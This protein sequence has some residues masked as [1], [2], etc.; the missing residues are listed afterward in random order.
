M[1]SQR[2]RYAPAFQLADSNDHKLNVITSYDSSKQHANSFTN[3]HAQHSKHQTSAIDQPLNKYKQ[4]YSLTE[5]HLLLHQHSSEYNHE[6]IQLLNDR[7]IK[8]PSTNN[9]MQIDQTNNQSIKPSVSTVFKFALLA[10]LVIRNSASTLII[11]YSQGVLHEKYSVMSTVLCAEFLKMFVCTI[12][13]MVGAS[14]SPSRF[15]SLIRSSLPMALPAVLYL[16]QNKLNYIALRSLPGAEFTI[17]LQLKLLATAI[18][19]RIILN[20]LINGAQWRALMLLFVGVILVQSTSHSFSR[21]SK[22][23][24]HAAYVCSWNVGADSAWSFVNQLYC[25]SSSFLESR[26]GFCAA[27]AQAILS[28][29]GGVY[30][31]RLLKGATKLSLWESNWQLSLYSMIVGTIYFYQSGNSTSSLFDHYSIW[32]VLSVL[33]QSIGGLLVSLILVHLD[34]IMKNFSSSVGMLFTSA[35]SMWLFNDYPVSLLTFACGTTVVILA[36]FAYS[37][38]AGAGSS[39]PQTQLGVVKSA[40]VA[41]SA[42]QDTVPLLQPTYPL[43]KGHSSCVSIASTDVSVDSPLSDCESEMY[44]PQTSPQIAARDLFSSLYDQ[45]HIGYRSQSSVV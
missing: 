4:H 31:E 10:A 8:Q 1:S 37:D 40:T 19:S 43:R 5:Q 11:R 23:I 24:D 44:S 16:A 27:V 15:V 14:W 25:S 3:N 20:K 21:P 35:I 13:V 30:T 17:L 38:A 6:G 32:P 34:S 12:G 41:E 36:V 42:S 22:D 39:A 26:V 18:L 2:D 28:S 33:V 7:S 45:P 29:L 9:E